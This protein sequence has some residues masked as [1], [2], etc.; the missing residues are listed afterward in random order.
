MRIKML[1]REMKDRKRSAAALVP[2]H[3]QQQELGSKHPWTKPAGAAVPSVAGAIELQGLA[4]PTPSTARYTAPSAGL[5][6]SAGVPMSFPG[7]LSPARPHVQ[8][9]DSQMPIPS[10][11][12]DRP[13]GLGGY[14]L[15]PHYHWTYYPKQKQKTRSF[16][17][18]QVM[19]VKPF[20]AP[21]IQGGGKNCRKCTILN[22]DI[23]GLPVFAS[24]LTGARKER[25]KEAAEWSWRSLAQML[26]KGGVWVGDSDPN[27]LDDD[28]HN[29]K[30][31]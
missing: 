23:T 14:N 20:L 2:R 17:P 16:Y 10:G 13:S 27:T 5:Y 29:G 26:E 22:I 3:Q 30:R 21:R 19:Q 4:G 11:Y 9:L 8:A 12:F 7:N 15:Q 31:G 28:P 6:C 18:P 25:V 1:E 24:F